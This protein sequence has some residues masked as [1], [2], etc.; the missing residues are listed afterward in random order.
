MGSV[1]GGGRRG[2]EIR[3]TSDERHAYQRN[4]VAGIAN[5]A[6]LMLGDTFLHPTIVLALFVSQISSSNLLVG[7][8]PAIASGVW[9]LPQLLAATVVQGRRRELP[10]VV[11]ASVIRALSVAVL[12]VLGFN[13]GDRSPSTILLIFFAAYTVYNLAAGFAN[14][15]MV[16]VTARAIPPRRRG[17]FYGQR[18]FWG[19]VFGFIA[20]FIIQRILADSG[21]F[22]ANFGL[23]FF[24]A[25]FC[26]AL[27]AYAAALMVEPEAAPAPRT[28]V[29][30]QLMEIPSVLA[31]DNFR[32]FLFFRCFL[33]LAAIADPFFV[34]YAQRQ[35][36]APDSIIGVYI[37]AMAIARFGSNLIWSPL[38]D[39]RGNR[40]VLQLSAL[41]RLTIPITALVLP[42]LL[43]WG[44]LQSHLSNPQALIYSSFGLVFVLYGIAISGQN[45]ANITY[46]LDVAPD[47]ERAAYVGLINTILG[48]VSFIPVLGGSLVDR[49]GFQFLFLVAFL[50]SLAGVLASGALHEPRVLGSIN[51]FSRQY[52]LPRSRRRLS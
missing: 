22:P 47:Q 36:N 29:G 31:D 15:P 26:L 44:P 32:R 38:A 21:H 23:L 2:S 9:F 33:S 16:D 52:I 10:F 25:F 7:L 37:S 4:T 18:S 42:P 49:F 11:V 35:L 40:L 5:G 27:G 39:R 13:A 24:A 1:R 30:G 43:R 14:V 12:G 19:G 8:V 45:L 41:L 17:F 48:V 46:I 50:I 51:L 6:L 28:S 20:G 3:F 34:V